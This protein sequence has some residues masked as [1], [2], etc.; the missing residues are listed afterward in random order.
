MGKNFKTRTVKG[1]KVHIID[2][3]SKNIFLISKKTTVLDSSRCV[4][5]KTVGFS[6][7]YRFLHFHFHD[8]RREMHGFWSILWAK[9]PQNGPKNP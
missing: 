7:K 4:C 5:V 6:E 2:D 1:S 3:I 9:S 8:Q